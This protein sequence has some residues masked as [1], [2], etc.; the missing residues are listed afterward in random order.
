[1]DARDDLCVAEAAGV[2]A[3]RFAAAALADAAAGGS[4]EVLLVRGAGDDAFAEQVDFVF[5]HGG[6]AEVVRVY[7]DGAGGV[8]RAELRHCRG[9]FAEPAHTLSVGAL[10]E[11][12]RAGQ[13]LC[14]LEW[15]H[16]NG[17]ARA[18]EVV[19]TM[20]SHRDVAL[21]LDAPARRT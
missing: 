5:R 21:G 8:A 15:K 20:A 2:G 11:A 6:G 4:A 19:L 12:L 13:T 9:S 14:R 18:V 10:R 3:G 17:G 16:G 7:V 1:M